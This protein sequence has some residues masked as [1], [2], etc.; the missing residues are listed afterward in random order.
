MGYLN[1]GTF[2]VI[3]SVHGRY[4]HHC[5]EASKK[6]N[7]QDG[8]NEETSQDWNGEEGNTVVGIREALVFDAKR[9]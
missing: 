7:D 1:S 2:G 5:H 8:T 9:L 6:T 3:E 4:T